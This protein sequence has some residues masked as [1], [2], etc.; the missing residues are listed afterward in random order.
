MK[1]SKPPIESRINIHH[2]GNIH[3][4]FVTKWKAI[5]LAFGS[6]SLTS[7]LLLES[8]IEVEKVTF[9][10]KNDVANQ[11]ISSVVDHA[12][13]TSHDFLNAAN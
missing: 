11:D 6:G 2:A 1:N 10:D 7:R 12:E 9:N 4:S 13:V 8:G 3:A 5:D